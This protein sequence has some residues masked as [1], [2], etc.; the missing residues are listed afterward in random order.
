MAQPQSEDERISA[1]CDPLVIL[2]NVVSDISKIG[3]NKVFE[4]HKV[5]ILY[6]LVTGLKVS[7]FA[8]HPS[9]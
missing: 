9:A 8:A 2:H 4:E 3:P 1:A 7:S 6:E 5:N